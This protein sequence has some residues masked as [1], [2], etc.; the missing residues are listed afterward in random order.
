MTMT[1]SVLTRKRG[2]T[3]TAIFTNGRE[4]WVDVPSCIISGSASLPSNQSGAGTAWAAGFLPGGGL[5]VSEDAGVSIGTWAWRKEH[6]A[7]VV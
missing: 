7:E 4:K 5:G 2:P 6:I 1:P 3:Q